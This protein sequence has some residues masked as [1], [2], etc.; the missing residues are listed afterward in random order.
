MTSGSIGTP[1]QESL[2]T[3]KQLFYKKSKG[4]HSRQR[5]CNGSTVLFWQPQMVSLTESWGKLASATTGE[6]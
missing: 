1:L 5:G 4:I 3:Q 2:T 6:V